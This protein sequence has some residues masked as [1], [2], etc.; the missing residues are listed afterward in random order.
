[1]AGAL[2]GLGHFR[3]RASAGAKAS[4]GSEAWVGTAAGLPSETCDPETSIP[5]LASE[6]N[7]LGTSS[8]LPPWLE[9]ALPEAPMAERLLGSRSSL[10]GRWGQRAAAWTNPVT[11]PAA[12]PPKFYRLFKP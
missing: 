7:T 5:D 10:R 3:S 8:T 2:V 9:L 4:T 6:H 1:M 11:V 12:L